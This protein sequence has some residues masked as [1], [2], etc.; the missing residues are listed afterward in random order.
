MCPLGF[1]KTLIV[2]FVTVELDFPCLS[3]ILLSANIL[4]VLR[5]SLFVRLF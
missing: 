5:Y 2:V 3:L 1:L 4:R